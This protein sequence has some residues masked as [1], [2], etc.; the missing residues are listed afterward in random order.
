MAKLVLLALFLGSIALAA[1]GVTGG[2]SQPFPGIGWALISLTAIPAI[3]Q[4]FDWLWPN[5]PIARYRAALE[6]LKNKIVGLIRR[7]AL[8]KLFALYGRQEITA[9]LLPVE[10]AAE[11][12]VSRA[13]KRSRRR[14]V[15]TA[16]VGFVVVAMMGVYLL[17]L[18]SIDSYYPVG[19]EFSLDESFKVTVLKEP[20]CLTTGGPGDSPSCSVLVRFR[21]ASHSRQS[22]GPGSFSL[23]RPPYGP[24][25]CY[26]S[27]TENYCRDYAAAIVGRD[28]Y[29]DY[30]ASDSTFPTHDLQP[31]DAL[32]AKLVFEVR[33]GI[34][35]DELQLSSQTK[36]GIVHILFTSVS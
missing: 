1:L 29:Y 34:I 36:H 9:R 27:D 32:N 30:D 2:L 28:N 33:K 5:A 22:I 16:A 26:Y 4:M 15:W 24:L 19:K 6:G 18:R 20:E 12:S 13:R 35:P 7:R 23:I 8:R 3:L 31:E 17:V 14:R 10:E 21:N 11:Y 25:Y